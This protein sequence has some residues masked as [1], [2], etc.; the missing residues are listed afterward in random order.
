[1]LDI[2]YTISHLNYLKLRNKCIPNAFYIYSYNVLYIIYAD[3]SGA[4][5][6]RNIY[7]YSSILKD[8]TIQIKMFMDTLYGKYSA[9]VKL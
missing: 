3:S 5:V 7:I 6:D 2:S 9:K 8:D 4:G 1:M